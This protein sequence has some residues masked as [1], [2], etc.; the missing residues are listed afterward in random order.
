MSENPE[1]VE[2]T[3]SPDF[4]EAEITNLVAAFYARVRKDDLIGPM[5]PASDWEGSEQRLRD[6]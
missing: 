2:P 1:A 5:Y 4:G 6:F 3:S